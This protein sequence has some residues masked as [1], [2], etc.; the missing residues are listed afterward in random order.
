LPVSSDTYL[1]FQR[2]PIAHKTQEILKSGRFAT[3]CVL[4]LHGM[5]EMQAEHALSEWLIH[6]HR[7]KDRFGVIVHGKG[8]NAS[9]NTPILKNFV[10]WWLR[11]QPQIA[12]LCSAQ[13]ADGGT[14]A[15]YVL[16]GS[17]S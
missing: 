2:E 16:M 11:N 6:C 12:A 14:G 5:N 8:N 9:D 3:R 13:A 17:N 4:D 1:Y 7:K 10:N 15:V